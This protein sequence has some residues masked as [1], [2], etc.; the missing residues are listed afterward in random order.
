MIFFFVSFYNN[1]RLSQKSYTVSF[2]LENVLEHLRLGISVTTIDLHCHHHWSARAERGSAR[3]DFFFQRYWSFF[4][5]QAP[6][7]CMWRAGIR[8]SPVVKYRLQCSSQR[9]Q[10][11]KKKYSIKW[12]LCSEC[13]RALT[14]ESFFFGLRALTHSNSWHAHLLR[15]LTGEFSKVF[16]FS[17]VLNQTKLC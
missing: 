10:I 6:L 17:S 3:D 13:T 8:G 12:L 11:K 5:C 4:A 2:I 14:C 7:I 15:L 16:S 1:L 9:S